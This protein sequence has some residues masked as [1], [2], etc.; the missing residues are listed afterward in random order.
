MTLAAHL[1]SLAAAAVLE[2]LRPANMSASCCKETRER[3]VRR[4]EMCDA[5]G[6]RTH[7]HR[8]VKM[9]C[10]LEKT[11]TGEAK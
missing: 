2:T 7:K 10:A 8:R 5:V 3:E 4:Y 6:Q 1:V 9:S 11:R